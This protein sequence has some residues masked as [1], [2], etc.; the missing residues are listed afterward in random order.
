M[1][2]L[3]LRQL[4]GKLAA[5]E[6]S[7]RELCDYYIQRIAQHNPDINAYITTTFEQACLAADASD[8]R[9]AK[10]ET[11]STLDG[12]P[13]A[14]KDI[15]CTKDIRTT[16]GSNMLANFIPSYDAGIVENLAK[17]GAVMT[18]KVSMD[19]FAMGSS[20]ER[21][22]FGAVK[23]P[24]HPEYVPGGSSGGSAAVVAARMV[25]YAT[26]SD[27]GGSIRQPAAY[28]GITGLKPTYGTLSRW[29][30]IAYASSLDQAGALAPCADDLAL[31]FNG[32]SGHDPRDS[33]ASTQ[34]HTIFDKELE[35]PLTGIK[36][37]LPRNY[38][39]DLNPQMAEIIRTAAALYE[40]LGA[41]LQDIDLTYS[42]AAIATYYIIASAEASSNLSRYD[43][44]RY[45]HRSAQAHNLQDM[46]R[47]SRSEGFGEEVK[48]RILIG[49]YALSAG[50]Y[51]AYYEQARR[52]RN[53][54]LGSFKTAFNDVDIILSPT[55]PTP[56]FK[57]G[58]QLD[59]PVTMFLGDLYTVSV[60]LAGLPAL[61]HPVGFIDG[62]P[63][64]CQL[65]GPHFSEPRL[66]NLAHQ[67]Q[68]NSDYHKQ[69]PKTYS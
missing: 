18:G 63:V 19:E 51:D 20:N 54:I 44:A 38:F 9:R 56:T 32:M 34:T 67:F 17:A 6:I 11:L 65:I 53:A 23:N 12:I 8:T 55:T 59:D 21:S 36:I 48:R 14:H 26:G 50:Y 64:G 43:G 2:T 31:I 61:S 7:A 15:F 52:A 22:A 25:P 3:S 68:Q 29:G 47:K 37:G 62:L 57:L 45:G 41:T 28:C 39:K 30:M 13:M 46:Y 42:D 33:T 49:T 5:Q 40:K 66:L 60:N 69:I 27:T 1:H 24:W 4:A 10:K 58:S 35:K 16:A